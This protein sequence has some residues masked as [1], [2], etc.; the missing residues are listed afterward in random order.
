MRRFR[1][2]LAGL[3]C[4]VA[5]LLFVLAAAGFHHSTVGRTGSVVVGVA[6][7]LLAGYL[8]WSVREAST[9]AS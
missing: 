1:R 6:L 8:L 4:L 7:L 2:P 5:V 3:L 9:P